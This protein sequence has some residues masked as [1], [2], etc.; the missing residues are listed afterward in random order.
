MA[1]GKRFGVDSLS[2][3]ELDSASSRSMASMS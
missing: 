2:E 1:E 3:A